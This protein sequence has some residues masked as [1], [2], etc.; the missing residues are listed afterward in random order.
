M[1]PYEQDQ[2]SSRRKSYTP[3]PG[4][5]LQYS[6]QDYFDD[7]VERGHRRAIQKNNAGG[8]ERRRSS[9]DQRRISS[10]SAAPTDSPRLTHKE[11]TSSKE[12]T[13]HRV[14]PDHGFPTLPPP[15]SADMYPA[16]PPSKKPLDRPSAPSR[17][18]HD[19]P[20]SG[21][22]RMLNLAAVGK[23]GYA[24][25]RP[26]INL[27]STTSKT[28]AVSRPPMPRQYSSARGSISSSTNLPS[29]YSQDG[30]STFV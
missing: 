24:V 30:Y 27:P 17:P 12:R 22:E 8:A 3:S 29:P 9:I 11:P 26:P 21:V 23:R 25:P 6:R 20:N 2:S 1:Y 18:S 13:R 28:Q 10:T 4:T 5:P 15:T 16:Y 14:N 19:K 7:Y